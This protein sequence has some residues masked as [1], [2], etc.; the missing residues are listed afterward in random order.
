MSGLGTRAAGPQP[1]MALRGAATVG[2]Q[3]KGLKVCSHASGFGI[4]PR[5]L[6]L[7]AAQ[8]GARP[9]PEPAQRSFVPD[10]WGLLV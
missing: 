9:A 8:E 2:D 4:L 7:K 1:S 10:G 6:D 5:P 3:R